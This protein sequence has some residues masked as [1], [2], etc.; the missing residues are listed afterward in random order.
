MPVDDFSSVVTRSSQ[1]VTKPANTTLSESVEY[2]QLIGRPAA[3][4][5][6]QKIGHP[7]MVEWERDSK[8]W[9]RALLRR[10]V[11]ASYNRT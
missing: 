3:F 9:T 7:S 5:I 8:L 10:H 6:E 11:W 2:G 4:F 1:D